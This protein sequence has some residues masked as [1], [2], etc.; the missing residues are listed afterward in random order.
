MSGVCSLQDLEA[1]IANRVSRT[2]SDQGF[3]LN[4]QNQIIGFVRLRHFH[5]GMTMGNLMLLHSFL[6]HPP[7]LRV[8]CSGRMG[9]LNCHDD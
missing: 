6:E 3:I 5:S 2:H 4:H 1:Q 8:Y 7:P 9:S